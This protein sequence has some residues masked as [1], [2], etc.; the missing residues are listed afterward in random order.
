VETV[1]AGWNK[2]AGVD[3]KE[4]REAFESW[5]PSSERPALYGKGNAAGEICQILDRELS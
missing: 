4:I 2:L 3:E 1:Q 5:H